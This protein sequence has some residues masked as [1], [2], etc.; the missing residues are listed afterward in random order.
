MGHAHALLLILH[1]SRTLR[2]G[3]EV[4]L[5]RLACFVLAAALLLAS[6]VT[7]ADQPTVGQVDRVQGAVTASQA[8]TAR[9]LATASALLFK[10]LLQTGAEARLAATLIDGTALT[11]G[12]EARLLIDELVYDP[13]G[14]SGKLLLNVVA[15]AF[16]F[17]G[18]KIEEAAGAD[19]VI[20]TPV[21]SIGIRGTT[22]WGGPI[23]GGYG[24]LVL[25]G[26]VTVSTT[27]GDVV[28]SAGQATMIFDP[29][30][31]PFP[32]YGWTQEKIDRAV[33]TIS[34]AE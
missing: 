10:D 17:V 22:V 3:L 24:V 13:A 8:Q 2:D 4:A 16:L 26:E 25:D 7:A 6:P 12:E 1:R 19:V 15:G 21:G 34:F 33:Q 32:G 14:G 31:G 9:P 29:A 11:L 23:D 27:G 30:R 28:L 18:G 20:R 5:K